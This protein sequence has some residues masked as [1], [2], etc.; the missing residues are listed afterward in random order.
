M[1]TRATSVPPEEQPVDLNRR[2]AQLHPAQARAKADA[3]DRAKRMLALYRPPDSR[4]NRSMQEVGDMFGITRQRVWELFHQH[5]PGIFENTPTRT[6]RAEHYLRGYR[7]PLGASH[8]AGLQTVNSA[9]AALRTVATPAKLNQ[10]DIRVRLG[11]ASHCWIKSIL[12][13]K[14]DFKVSS[15]GRIAWAL[16]CSVQISLV[17]LSKQDREHFDQEAQDES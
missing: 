15:L 8:R 1:S 17:P 2:V 3:Y 13:G 12:E 14:C 9:S 6:A 16:G 5:F 11:T 10:Q 7:D 4:E